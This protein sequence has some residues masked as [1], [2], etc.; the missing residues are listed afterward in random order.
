MSTNLGKKLVRKKLVLVLDL[1]NNAL[2]AYF[3]RTRLKDL[4]LILKEKDLILFITQVSFSL[5]YVISE[6]TSWQII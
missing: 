2:T 3:N 6:F 5:Y 4:T 1:G